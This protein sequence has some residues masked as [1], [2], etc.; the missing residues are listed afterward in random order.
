MLVFSSGRFF[1]SCSQKVLRPSVPLGTLGGPSSARV[2]LDRPSPHVEFRLMWWQVKRGRV[3]CRRKV[4]TEPRAGLFFRLSGRHHAPVQVKYHA[5]SETRS[6][7]MTCTRPGPRLAP[8]AVMSLPT[9]ARRRFS[10]SNGD[11]SSRPPARD[12][13]K[14]S[15][16]QP[17]TRGNLLC[18]R[19]TGN[20]PNRASRV[21][22]LTTAG[23][24]CHPRP[25]PRLCRCSIPTAV[26]TPTATGRIWNSPNM[27]RSRQNCLPCPRSGVIWP[28]TPQRMRQ[29]GELSTRGDVGCSSHQIVG[30]SVQVSLG[31]GNHG[32]TRLIDRLRRWHSSQRRKFG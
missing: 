6:D 27:H 1:P 28:E 4:A 29:D 24:P 10:R 30:R 14:R 2:G 13:V 11:H 5:K 32:K 19:N 18:P 20:R 15:V 17:P 25:M 22:K 23:R 8:T 7:G 21:A 31:T 3:Q 16:L 26:E 12:A 9:S